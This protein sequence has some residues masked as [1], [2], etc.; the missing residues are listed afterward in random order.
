[1]V[2]E[3]ANE[4]LADFVITGNITDVTFSA[5]KQTKIVTAKEYWDNYTPD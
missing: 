3:L 2:L 1:M 4:C 5:Y